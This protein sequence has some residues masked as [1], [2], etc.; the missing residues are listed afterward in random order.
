MLLPSKLRRILR[1]AGFQ[2]VQ[3]PDYGFWFDSRGLRILNIAADVLMRALPHD[4]F[5]A[6]AN[7]IA[8]KP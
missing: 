1:D 8:R 2:V 6:T 4:W 7:A 3:Q 5:S